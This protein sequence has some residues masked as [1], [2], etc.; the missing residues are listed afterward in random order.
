MISITLSIGYKL[1]YF[2]TRHCVYSRQI[3]PKKDFDNPALRELLTEV[4]VTGQRVGGAMVATRGAACV[5]PKDL[6]SLEIEE[7][8][9]IIM[10]K[11]ISLNMGL[12][13]QKETH[14][15]HL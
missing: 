7:F 6:K 10:L 13:A 4:H 1:I 8:E 15:D 5:G 12:R 3:M 2:D 14:L 11:N 9:L